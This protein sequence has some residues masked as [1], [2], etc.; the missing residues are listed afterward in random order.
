MTGA[1]GQ[2]AW[3][4]GAPQLWELVLLRA[5]SEGGQSPGLRPVLTPPPRPVSPGEMSGVEASLYNVDPP[6]STR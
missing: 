4:R 2:H 6:E 1:L 5:R 3:Q